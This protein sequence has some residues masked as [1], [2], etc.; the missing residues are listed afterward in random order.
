MAGTMATPS[1]HLQA[2][3]NN[4]DWNAFKHESVQWQL[5]AAKQT[6]FE[7]PGEDG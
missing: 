4:G 6:W 1:I 3:N 2:P 7:G 5:L